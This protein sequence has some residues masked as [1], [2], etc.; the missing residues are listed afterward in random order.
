MSS[1]SSSDHRC[2]LSEE[3]CSNL[4]DIERPSTSKKKSSKSSVCV[5]DSHSSREK[6]SQS[7]IPLTVGVEFDSITQLEESVAAFGKKV[8]CVYYKRD[9]TTIEQ[10]KNR[11][12]S[13]PLNANLKYYRLVYRCIHGGKTFKSLTKG[14]RS[15][16][17]FQQECP[18]MIS[19]ICNRDGNKLVLNKMI[20]NHNHICAKKLYD[21]LPQVRAMTTDEKTQVKEL[22][23]IRADKKM[24]KQKC[25]YDFDKKILL[26]DLSNLISRKG[27]QN[28]LKNTVEKLEK[29]Y[30]AEC[31]IFEEDKEMKGLLFATPHMKQSMAAYFE[32]VGIDGTFKLLNIRAPVYLMVVE[33]SEGN[34]EIVAVC[35]LVN[36]DAES[37][38]WFLQ[39][40]K[41]IHPSWSKTR[42]IMADKDLLERRIIKEEFKNANVLICTFHSLRT[43]NRE[44]SCEKLPITPEQRDAAKGLFQKMLYSATESEYMRYYKEVEKLPLAI[45]NYFNKNWHPI[46]NEWTLSN[47]FMQS[48]FLNTTNN[49][50]ESL[51]AKV[52]SVVKLYSTLEEFIESLFILITCLDSERDSKAAYNYQ[53][54]LVIPYEKD[55][56]EWLYCRYLTR[57]A[58]KFVSK[59]LES[60]RR[61]KNIFTEQD[62][63]HFEFR[64]GASTVV[65]SENS[66]DC[67]SFASMMLPCRHIFIVRKQL[68]CDLFDANI[69]ARR[70]TQQYYFHTQRVFQN[71]RMDDEVISGAV[72]SSKPPKRHV[73]TENQR[74]R[75]IRV[76]TNDLNNLGCE[77]SGDLFFRRLGLLNKI[78]KAWVE[79]CEV[80][81]SPVPT[82]VS[83]CSNVTLPTIVSSCPNVTFS[84][85]V[86]SSSNTTLSTIVTSSSNIVL[87]TIVT[88]TPISSGFRHD[89]HFDEVFDVTM[90][91]SLPFEEIDVNQNAVKR[92]IDCGEVD[93]GKNV[94]RNAVKRSIDCGE[95]DEGKN[96]DSCLEEADTIRSESNVDLNNIEVP[97]ALKRRGRPRGSL[98]TIIGLPK[99]R[100]VRAQLRKCAF[101]NMRL[102]DRAFFLLKCLVDEETAFSAIEHGVVIEEQKVQTRPNEV[103]DA[104]AD[105]DVNIE[106]IKRYFSSDAWKVVEHIITYKKENDVFLCAMCTRDLDSTVDDGSFSSNQKFSV[107]CD[108]CMSWY[109]L[110]CVS[111]KKPP[112][113]KIWKCPQC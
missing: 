85:I 88:S 103:L 98:K 15:S 84:T 95:N 97:C 13:R 99:K 101:F 96:E 32:F 61:E 60:F 38:T 64:L 18:A 83:S 3:S 63:D 37:M 72:V 100:R 48:T 6:N 2:D 12:I 4:S 22:L 26:K 68:G 90:S 24:V 7:V 14:I 112:T 35:I 33:D 16:S 58:F 28:N 80:D 47:D 62:D 110:T 17:T 66:C 36:E 42:C 23:D 81:V 46:R 102:K 78:R 75:M 91:E 1:S 65:A 21:F 40:F 11:G 34:T 93:E 10:C 52:K 94:N 30:G 67:P 109:H 31:H 41:K 74:F 77:V 50:I 108:Y 51:N 56:T 43:F 92:S 49:R 69:C 86:T 70:W 44:V 57:R 25:G 59:E 71:E 53:K 79:N 73:S 8:Y 5:G 27:G 104:V 9:S 19:F 111:L 105:A 20:N 113:K 54:M 89:S 45:V 82:I 107:R 76:I 106:S 55:T 39:A 29:E 87:P